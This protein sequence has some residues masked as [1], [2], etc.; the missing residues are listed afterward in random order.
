[1]AIP[2]IKGNRA[3]F[4]DN[5]PVE[6]RGYELNSTIREIIGWATSPI[7]Y[8]S[9]GR[10]WRYY[11]RGMIVSGGGACACV[12][13]GSIL[14]YYAQTGQFRGPLGSPTTDVTSVWPIG[15]VYAV[16]ENGVVWDGP[17]AGPL[18]LT[19]VPPILVQTVAQVDSTPDGIVQ[20]AQQKIQTVADAELQ[21]NERLSDNVEGIVA[22]VQA[23]E[24]WRM[25]LLLLWWG[26]DATA[27]PYLQSPPRLRPQ[28]VRWSDW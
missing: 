24:G 4:N 7:Y 28:G 26:D 23:R 8:D 12:L 20:F 25:R 22:S 27:F 18:E 21:T 10:H 5:N 9:D 13:W 6:M 14:N 16:F 2:Q 1:M 3:E 11:E 17:G 19:P 15:T